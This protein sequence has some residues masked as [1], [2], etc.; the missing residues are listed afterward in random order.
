[1]LSPIDSLNII[2]LEQKYSDIMKDL[3]D[4][5]AKIT[6]SERNIRKAEEDLYEATLAHEQLQLQFRGS[7]TMS[8]SIT[9]KLLQQTNLNMYR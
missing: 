4:L 2:Q 7:V 9:M 5:D 3:S 1:M 8:Q 6:S